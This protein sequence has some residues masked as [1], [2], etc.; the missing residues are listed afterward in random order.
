M[1][2]FRGGVLCLAV[3]VGV[4]F[5]V[6]LCIWFCMQMLGTDYPSTFGDLAGVD[7]IPTSN[8]VMKVLAAYSWY[9]R[10]GYLQYPRKTTDKLA[11]VQGGGVWCGFGPLRILGC[12]KQHRLTDGWVQIDRAWTPRQHAILLARV[13]PPHF[14]SYTQG[15]ESPLVVGS[16]H[17]AT[18]TVHPSLQAAHRRLYFISP[19]H[20]HHHHHHLQG[21]AFFECKLTTTIHVSRFTVG[22][23][24]SPMFVLCADHC[25][26]LLGLVGKEEVRMI[27]ALGPGISS[28]RSQRQHTEHR[29]CVRPQCDNDNSVESMHHAFSMHR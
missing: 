10:L 19:P 14:S 9:C 24:M 1:I 23:S 21:Y 29:A 18:G 22:W 27:P 26:D 3:P 12:Q 11:G 15:L 2:L 4:Q 28:R 25:A 8:Y 20:H 5:G 13:R 6:L 7:S 17:T 16:C